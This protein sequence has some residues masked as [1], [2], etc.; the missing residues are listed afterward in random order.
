MR[1]GLSLSSSYLTSSPA[2][3][4]ALDRLETVVTLILARRTHL[5]ETSTCGTLVDGCFPLPHFLGGLVPYLED[6]RRR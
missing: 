3:L 2:Q 6:V 4:S 5:I 1:K